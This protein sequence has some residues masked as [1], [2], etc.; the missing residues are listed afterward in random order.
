MAGFFCYFWK[1][2][3]SRLAA[4]A[5][6]AAVLA[7]Q[8]PPD[9]SARGSISG[10][11]VHYETGRPISRV[12]VI[13]Q[14]VSA[15]TSPV[16]AT[17]ARDGRFRFRRL[18]SGYYSIRAQH[19][20]YLPATFAQTEFTRLPYVFGLMPGEKL[21]NIVIRL[22]PAGVISGRVE[23]GDGEPAV[24]VPVQ[25]YREY[26]FRG[27][28]GFQLA[29]TARTDDRGLYRIYGL[30]PGRY[31][32]VAAYSPPSPGPG[33][34]EQRPVGEDGRP[35]PE[36]RFVTTYYP[37]THRMIEAAPVRLRRSEQLDHIDITLVRARVARIR[38]QVVS[39]VTGDVLMG[40]DVR[41]RQPSPVADVLVDAPA[42]VRPQ[43]DG[44]FEITGVTPGSYLV[45]VNAHENGVRLTARAPVT[46]AGADVENFSITAEPYR[47]LT[48]RVVSDD[49]IDFPLSLFRVTLEPASDS[50]PATSASVD[51]EGRF[52]VEFVPGE[53]Y[54]VFLLDGP[55]DVYLESARIGG[56]DVLR[57]GFQAETGNL[58]PMELRFSTKGAVVRGE[59]A[60][61]ATKVALGATVA[62]VP[63]PARGRIQYFKITTTDAYGIYEFRGVAPG[64]YTLLAWWDEPPCEVYDI[65][66]L[67]ACRE[68]GKSIEVRQGESQLINLAVSR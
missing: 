35:L 40:S 2:M 50:V 5:A 48:G 36:E 60:D 7:A 57:T 49:A 3:W 68:A 17:T 13:L 42:S 16:A 43:P 65:E 11:V 32:I 27:R 1:Q 31:Y 15:E 66:S 37:S 4:V 29:G 54:E 23:F 62:L 63:D 47:A 20:G 8:Y 51:E 61:S 21:D 56:F 67:E 9:P 24:G 28:H 45:V 44:G 10:R 26:F 22:R 55:P 46:V 52:E 58:P 39:A 59:V 6:V 14:P 25:F 18:P 64:R 53:T 30:P 41:L 12:Q 38:G 33:V 34:R 19:A